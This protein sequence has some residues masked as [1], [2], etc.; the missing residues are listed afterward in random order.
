MC[1]NIVLF[2]SNRRFKFLFFVQLFDIVLNLVMVPRK[3]HGGGKKI[4]FCG[5]E[6][7]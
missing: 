3:G 7:R 2:H 6:T 5:W 4:M 1:V